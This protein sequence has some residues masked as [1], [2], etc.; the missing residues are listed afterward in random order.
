LACVPIVALHF[1]HVLVCFL[2]L[3][4]FFFFA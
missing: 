3:C 4:P 2:L 1:S